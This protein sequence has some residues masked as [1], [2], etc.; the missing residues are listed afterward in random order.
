MYSSF[1][2]VQT[3]L[4]AFHK[5]VVFEIAG[6]EKVFDFGDTT[7]VNRKKVVA[8]RDKVPSSVAVRYVS[9]NWNKGT[10]FDAIFLPLSSFRTDKG[11]RH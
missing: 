1:K 5:L 10:L 4:Y 7:I 9:E 11:N 3:G 2:N 6:A 8:K